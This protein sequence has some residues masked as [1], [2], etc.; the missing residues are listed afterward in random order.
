M[1]DD[2]LGEGQVEWAVDLDGQLLRHL[3]VRELAAALKNPVLDLPGCGINW[4]RKGQNVVDSIIFNFSCIGYLD[5]L[6]K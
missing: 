4:I 3:D 5:L 1:N 2:L 6:F